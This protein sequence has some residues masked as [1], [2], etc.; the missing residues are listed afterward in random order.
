MLWLTEHGLGSCWLGAI[1]R[2]ETRDFLGLPAGQVVPLLIC[3]GKPKPKAALS[4]DNLMYQTVSRRRKPLEADR[5]FREHEDPLPSSHV[6]R[7]QCA[8]RR[9]NRTSTA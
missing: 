8:R 1:N 7:D 2:D 9:R 6:Y 5:L 3:V 4:M